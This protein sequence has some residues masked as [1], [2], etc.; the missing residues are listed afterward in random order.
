MLLMYHGCPL[1]YLTC[2]A[3]S[4]I[5]EFSYTDT[6]VAYIFVYSFIHLCN[7]SLLIHTAIHAFHFYLFIYVYGLNKIFQFHRGNGFGQARCYFCPLPTYIQE[8]NK[9]K[10]K[11]CCFCHLPTYIYKKKLTHSHMLHICIYSLFIH[12]CIYLFVHLSQR[13]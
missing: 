6:P 10:Q 5:I 3:V 11:R 2:P 9:L 7:Y 12:S 13:Y 4:L 8:K 1:W